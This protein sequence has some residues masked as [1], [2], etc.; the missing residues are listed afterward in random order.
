MIRTN[1]LTEEDLDR[2]RVVQDGRGVP[3]IIVYER[4]RDEILK[5]QIPTVSVMLAEEFGAVAG[6]EIY[7]AEE[8]RAED[9][10]TAAERYDAIM[11]V[12]AG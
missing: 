10:L 3:S 2:I 4:P 7:F 9:G 5:R 1:Y 12:L 8:P 6:V 11:E